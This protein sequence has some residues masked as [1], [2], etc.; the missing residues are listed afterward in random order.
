MS[1][2][3]RVP[4]QR[5]DG[6]QLPAQEMA[7]ERVQVRRRNGYSVQTGDDAFGRTVLAKDTS[8]RNSVSR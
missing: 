6:G 8:K 2:V 4:H 5:G 3:T 7:E 1:V